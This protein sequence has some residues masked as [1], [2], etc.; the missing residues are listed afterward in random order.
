MRFIPVIILTALAFLA[1]V[2]TQAATFQSPNLAEGWF[3]PLLIADGILILVIL[4]AVVLMAY[5]IGAAWRRGAPGGRLALRLGG[6][7]LAVALLPSVLLYGISAAG[8]FRSID[9]W[10]AT[11]LGRA[12]E[13]GEAFGKSV[14]EGEFASLETVARDMANNLRGRDGLPFWVEDFRLFHQLD[15]V[16]L[17]DGEGR[18]LATSGEEADGRL[19]GIAL[20]KLRTEPAHRDLTASGIAVVLR[21][22]PGAGVYAVRLVRPLPPDLLAGLREVALGQREYNNLLAVRR[23]LR[24]SFFLTL[25]LAFFMILLAAAA[26]ALWL[27]RRL[28]HPLV[29]MAEATAAVGHGDFSRRLP[30]SGS[31]EIARL[32]RAF[33]AMVGDL[34]QSR[35]KLDKRRAALTK[36]NLY[37]ENLLASLTSG[38]LVF[39]DSGK[40]ARANAGASRLLQT[41]MKKL[42]GKYVCGNSALAAINESVAAADFDAQERRLAGPGNSTLVARTRRLAPKAGGTVLV[43]VDDITRQM[44]EEREAAW[45]EASRRFAHEIKNPLTPIRLARKDWGANLPESCHQGNRKRWRDWR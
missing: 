41:D 17:Y 9:S 25:T 11:P 43:V 13:Q 35:R 8:I 28:S 18:A 3:V 26:A 45:E 34:G 2:L 27:G 29:K 21:M 4:I 39:D 32:N 10:F 1:L 33:N 24:L 31:D 14:L 38:V 7:L 40:L 6:V 23:G 20:A 37:L 36:A 5:R 19:S 12:F 15:G 30:E 16:A 44:Q 22:P 42:S